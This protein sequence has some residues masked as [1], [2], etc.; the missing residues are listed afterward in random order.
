[1]DA[2][3]MANIFEPF[4]TTKEQGKGTGL[5]LSTAYGIVKQSGGYILAV[6]EPGHGSCFKIYLPRVRAAVEAA[7]PAPAR[8]LGGNETI[9]LVEDDEMIR[10]FI[11]RVLKWYGYNL[12]EACSPAEA[13][14]LSENRERPIHLLLTDIVMPGMRGDEMANL[15]SPQRPDMKIIFTSGYTEAGV[16][17]RDL[18]GV[19][20]AFIQKPINPG[21]LS[22]TVRELLDGVKS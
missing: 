19:G 11:A 17:R 21:A 12:L 1:M 6:S 18:Q 22:R 13:I 9:L 2:K 14:R 3:T 16:I 8:S 5:G 10:K 4:F 7:T 20:T 15:L